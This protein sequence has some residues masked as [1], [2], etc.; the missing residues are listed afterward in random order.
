MKDQERIEE[1]EKAL[2]QRPDVESINRALL[3]GSLM[4]SQSGL[5]VLGPKRA[6]QQT[7]VIRT[8]V[9]HLPVDVRWNPNNAGGHRPRRSEVP[10]IPPE[11]RRRIAI[12]VWHR[13]CLPFDPLVPNPL[14]GVY[15]HG[16]IWAGL[17]RTMPAQCPQEP[18][19]PFSHHR[20]V[21]GVVFR[22][23]DLQGKTASLLQLQPN[24]DP[25]WPAFG[26]GSTAGLV[27]ANARGRDL[28][29]GRGTPP[30]SVYIPETLFEW[31]EHVVQFPDAAVY[32]PADKTA[33][34]ALNQRFGCARRLSVP[35]DGSTPQP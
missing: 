22:T 28:L 23:Y 32:G 27:L 8:P 7:P 10:V 19:W 15:A 9:E 12:Q 20:H 4:L 21:G 31:M 14:I 3:D 2:A 35:W 17:A 29:Q 18:W 26:K 33:R 30:T 24:G 5:P 25:R 11:D 1:L 6:P 16:E 34:K 13:L